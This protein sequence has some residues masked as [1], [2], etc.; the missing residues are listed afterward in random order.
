[1]SNVIKFIERV[2]D[3]K[4]AARVA[5]LA[6]FLNAGHPNPSSEILKVADLAIEQADAQIA[7]LIAEG[8]LKVSL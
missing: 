7:Q 6:I 4:R 8:K 3:R 1:M 5:N 2:S